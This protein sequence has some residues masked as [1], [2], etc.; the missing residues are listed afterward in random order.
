M[1]FAYSVS[2][3]GRRA[4]HFTWRHAWL[5]IT[6]ELAIGVLSDAVRAAQPPLTLGQAQRLAIKSFR[7]LVADD[8]AIQASREMAV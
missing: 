5:A 2:P 4:A 3:T 6:H 7:Q 1:Y 8:A